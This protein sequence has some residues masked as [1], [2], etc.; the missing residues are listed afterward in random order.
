MRAFEYHAPTQI[1]F[2]KD[3][4]SRTGELVK[5]HGGSRVLVVYGGESAK[6]SGLLDRVLHSLKQEQ[7]ETEIH[8]GA[9]PN[10]RLSFAKEGL[11]KAQAFRADFVLAIGGGSAIDAA[12]GIADGAGN[13]DTGLWDIWTRKAEC[14]GALPVGVVLTIPAAGSETS[15]SAVLTNDD[16]RVKRGLSLPYHRPRFAV[17]NPELAFSLPRY[18]LA[19]GVT[20]IMMHTMERYFNP[21]TENDLTDELAE[22]LLRAVIKNG[23]EALEEGVT[24]RNMSEIM[25][26]GSISHVGLTGLGNRGDWATHQLGH[27][28]SARFDLAHGASLAAVWASWARYCVAENPARFARYGMRVLGIDGIGKTEEA[29]ADSAI[30]RTEALFETYGMPTCFSRTDF[31]ILPEETLE[32]LAVRCTFYGE[33]TIGTFKTLD[34][35]DILAI[36]KL[37]N[38]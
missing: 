8:G 37:A 38:R 15:D 1:V 12:K 11:K 17:M 19:C 18:Q 22:G 10:P 26:A 35:D 24:Y 7:I 23:K 29:V 32:D 25:W 34:R 27:E 14:K 20:D 36:Y 28:L 16:T 31:G 30:D 33:R 9:M 4:E 5:Q 2:G 13:P 3:T 21:V 6:K